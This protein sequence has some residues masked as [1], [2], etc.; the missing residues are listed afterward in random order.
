MMMFAMVK[1]EY[2]GLWEDKLVKG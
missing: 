2:L 1:K